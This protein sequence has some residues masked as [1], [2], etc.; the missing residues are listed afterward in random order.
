MY[1]LKMW[2]QNLNLKFKFNFMLSPMFN[3][4]FHLNFGPR[5]QG[6]VRTTVVSCFL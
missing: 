1:I 2:I 5:Q 6:H 4:L 3:M